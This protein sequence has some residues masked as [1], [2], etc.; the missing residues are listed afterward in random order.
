[1]ATDVIERLRHAETLPP[2]LPQCLR[3]AGARFHFMYASFRTVGDC[4][5]G[6]CGQARNCC[7]CARKACGHPRKGCDCARG[8][9]GQARNCCEGGPAIIF[10]S[11]SLSIDKLKKKRKKQEPL[12]F[13]H[14]SLSPP[15]LSAHPSFPHSPFL[16][17]PLLFAR[18]SLLF[19]PCSLLFALCS[20]PIPHSSL[21]LAL[22]LWYYGR[23]ILET[24][25]IQYI[26]SGEIICQ[27]KIGQLL[28]IRLS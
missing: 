14:F 21:L 10:I 20:F 27:P 3:N 8:A 11:C 16:I 15:F 13:F 17:L 26:T 22:L 4:A 18:C 6:A 19:A 23:F 12:L 25:D 2:F 24:N 28:L 1:M 7:E 5:R 9:C